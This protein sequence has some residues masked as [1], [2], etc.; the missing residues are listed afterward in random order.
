VAVVDRL[1]PLWDFEDLDASERRFREQLEREE[2]DAD[3][4]EVL[5]QIAR[6]AGL[7]GDFEACRRL[8]DEAERLARSSEVAKVR[9][10]LE[11]GR[12][13]RSD[14]DQAAAFPLFTSAFEHAND[15]GEHYLAGDAAHM[16]AIATPDR[17]EMERWTRR[18]LD[19]AEQEPDAAYWAGPL[20][21]NLAWEYYEACEYER[22]LDLF[23]R[24][25]E[26]RLRDPANEA[27][28][29]WSRHGVAQALRALGRDEEADV[30]MQ[31]ALEWAGRAGKPDGYFSG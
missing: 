1:R 14:G 13:L 8:L 25:L 11:R 7:R 6:V 31:P 4:A 29:A 18:G 21:N 12:M 16:A 27:G 22:A 9:I 28:I 17:G 2:S 5:T 19:L 15:A 23:N 10:E 20:L 30:A 3:R 26:A 24:A